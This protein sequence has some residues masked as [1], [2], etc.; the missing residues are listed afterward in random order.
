[1]PGKASIQRCDDDSPALKDTVR[2]MISPDDMARADQQITRSDYKSPGQ[3]GQ[4]CPQRIAPEQPMILLFLKAD[5]AMG[6]RVVVSA[7]LEADSGMRRS[8]R[9][10]E[11]SM[12]RSPPL[13]CNRPITLI[14]RRA[15]CF[16]GRCLSMQKPQILCPETM[17]QEAA[18][19]LRNEIALLASFDR[20]PHFTLALDQD[21]WSQ[22]A[23]QY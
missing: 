20:P 7:Y 21:I 11:G 15:F 23:E 5:R 6:W 2:K 22:I 8:K 9:L 4:F 19:R 14:G 12:F 16:S 18:D 3:A 1:M 17:L 10:R 13:P